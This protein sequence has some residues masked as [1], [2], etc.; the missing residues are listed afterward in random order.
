M[1]DILPN[2]IYV[3]KNGVEVKIFTDGEM[4]YIAYE[5][6][7][8]I[9]ALLSTVDTIEN[10]EEKRKNC[11]KT[12]TTFYSKS[13]TT[14]TLYVHFFQN[15][16][17]NITEMFTR[18]EVKN[19]EKEKEIR[20]YADGTVLIETRNAYNMKIDAKELT[21]SSELDEN[22]VLLTQEI[23]ELISEDIIIV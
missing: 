8:N 13:I 12:K 16:S 10:I 20:V 11:F 7:K 14:P 17:K 18:I 19:K 6:I 1:G 21:L 5:T 15:L 23:A 9:Q 22:I 4:Q 3:F 2:K